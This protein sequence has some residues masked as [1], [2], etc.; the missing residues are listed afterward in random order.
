MAN[1]ICYSFS[2]NDCPD[3]NISFKDY[4]VKH[5]KV[6]VFA[7]F[8]FSFISYT[9]VFISSSDKNL[10]KSTISWIITSKQETPNEH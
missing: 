2:K 7:A 1:F 4:D 3:D 10:K 9:N 8:S 6:C 5:Y